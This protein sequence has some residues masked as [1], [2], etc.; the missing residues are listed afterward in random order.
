LADAVQ[1]VVLR[2]NYE[3]CTLVFNVRHVDGK[4][5][6]AA[7]AMSKSLTR[8]FPFLIGVHLF[9]GDQDQGYYLGTANSASHP[10]VRKIFGKDLV[11]QRIQGLHFL[12]SPVSFSQIN[13]SI[14]GLL[15]DRCSQ[16]LQLQA[17][18]TL[19]DLYSGFG[20]FAISLARNVTKVVAAES[21]H[22]SVTSAIENAKRNRINNIRFLR[23]TI[24]DESIGEIVRQCKRQDVVLLDPP[25]GGTDNGVLEAIAAQKPR[26]V[27]HLFCN[28]NVIRKELDR[29]RA[30]GYR[31]CE[32]VPFDMFPGTDSVEI[33]VNLQPDE[34]TAT[35]R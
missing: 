1:Y 23:S 21:F 10:V 18:D 13:L 11:Y 2:G 34:T 9:R 7:N 19:F 20:L 14:T 22:P 5:I 33:L 26:S 15:I 16:L 28:V 29:W 24:T 17:S 25:R 8:E 31:V 32:V 6:S 12:F 30:S 4:V 3:E 35:V 27:A